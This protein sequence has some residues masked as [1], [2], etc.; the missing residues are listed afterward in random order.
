MSYGLEL[1]L[2]LYKHKLVLSQRGKVLTEIC[3]IRGK[4]IFPFLI[5]D[6]VAIYPV[7]IE[8]TEGPEGWLLLNLQILI[9]IMSSF[10][11]V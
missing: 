10:N 6:K 4:E 11:I 2:N 9:D 3:N 5:F 7:K 1:T 8:Y